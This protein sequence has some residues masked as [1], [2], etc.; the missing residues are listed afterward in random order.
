MASERLGIFLI[1][2]FAATSVIA[3][4]ARMIPSGGEVGQL[5]VI[6][7]VGGT[8]CTGELTVATRPIDEKCGLHQNGY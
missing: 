7:G 3:T 4:L 8:P 5:G 1:V 2:L 6:G